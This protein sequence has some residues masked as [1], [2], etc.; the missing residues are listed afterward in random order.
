[1]KKQEQKEAKKELLTTAVFIWSVWVAYYLTMKI[2][3]I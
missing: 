3:T 1:M 2:I